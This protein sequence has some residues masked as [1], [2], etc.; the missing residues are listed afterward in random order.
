MIISSCYILDISS[1]SWVCYKEEKCIFKTICVIKC[2]H[3][4][5]IKK[6][7]KLIII[8]MNSFDLMKLNI[9]KTMSL[10]INLRLVLQTT[11]YIKNISYVI[12]I[13]W[14]LKYRELI[15]K[16]DLSF[17]NNISFHSIMLIILYCDKICLKLWYANLTHYNGG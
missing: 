11:S 6:V 15:D 7:V 14:Y 8:R 4:N 10:S 13:S 9:T 12:Y 16:A 5:I 17:E 2:V 1:L 3:T